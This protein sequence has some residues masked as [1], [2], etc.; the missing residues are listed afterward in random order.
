MDKPEFDTPSL[1]KYF[2]LSHSLVEVGKQLLSSGTSTF[3]LFLE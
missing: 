1:V 2:Y 3:S